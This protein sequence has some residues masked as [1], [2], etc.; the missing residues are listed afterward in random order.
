MSNMEDYQRE[1]DYVQNK[2][3]ILKDTKRLLTNKKWDWE[4]LPIGGEFDK[5]FTEE[6]QNELNELSEYIPGLEKYLQ[7]LRNFLDGYHS[8]LRFRKLYFN[9]L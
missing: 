7:E 4:Q 3:Y 8:I 9:G 6:D 5:E 2:I 1:F